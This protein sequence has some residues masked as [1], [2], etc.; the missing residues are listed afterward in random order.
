MSNFV[1]V[2][3]NGKEYVDQE[4]FN[5][6]IAE[7]IL[8]AKNCQYGTVFEIYKDNRHTTDYLHG[9]KKDNGHIDWVRKRFQER[10]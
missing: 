1:L 8:F 6:E 5:N 9:E 4:I 3:F 2:I 7:C 10:G